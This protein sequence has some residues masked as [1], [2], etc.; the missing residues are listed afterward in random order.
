MAS[1]ALA[2]CEQQPAGEAVVRTDL[3]GGASGE[4][5]EVVEP[6]TR[7]EPQVASACTALTFEET[8][9]THCIADPRAHT[10]RT[11][12]A[13]QGGQ[14]YGSL[15]AF[16]EQVEA[17]RIAFVVNGGAFGDDRRAIG[18]YVEDGERLSELDRGDGEGN[19]YMKP[20]GVFFGGPGGWRVL[21][22]EAFFSTVRDRPQFGTQS[23]P[24]LV[25]GGEMHPE[26]QDDGASRAVR[27]AV[28]VDS[29]GRAHFVI[30]D[31]EVSFG[32]I[33]RLYR[34]ELGISDALLLAST[35]SALWDPATGRLDNGR[36]GPIIVVENS[37]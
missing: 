14:P 20:N 32:K 3:G 35:T 5:A 22:T 28:G 16:A 30:A 26:F 33:A 15:A 31:D 19:F 37:E 10:I 6:E 12:L 36:A 11:A 24:M 29:Q 21:S 7:E 1:L 4:T 27:N 34:D 9:F 18:Y 2:A 25:V 23:G 13:P 8:A 17:G